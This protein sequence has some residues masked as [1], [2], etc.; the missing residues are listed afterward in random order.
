M[1]L[2]GSKAHAAV[3]DCDS[4]VPR[5]TTSRSIATDE[6]DRAKVG[7]RLCKAAVSYW[8]SVESGRLIGR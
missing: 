6:S 1:R 2:T 3:I 7:D 4:P 5:M 8:N